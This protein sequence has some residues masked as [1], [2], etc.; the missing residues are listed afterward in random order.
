MGFSTST[1]DFGH[2]LAYTYPDWKATYTLLPIK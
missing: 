2:S 1:T